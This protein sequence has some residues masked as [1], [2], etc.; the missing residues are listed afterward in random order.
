MK[1]LLSILTVFILSLVSILYF[2]SK[3]NVD[4]KKVE[5]KKAIASQVSKSNSSNS[6]EK[7]QLKHKKRRKA[8][9]NE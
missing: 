1:N 6:I 3:I 9:E 2:F 5:N 4:A 7:K 8:S